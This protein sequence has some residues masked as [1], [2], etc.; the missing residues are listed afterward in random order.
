MSDE[1]LDCLE[2]PPK[3]CLDGPLC[4][5]ATTLT[6]RKPF[7]GKCSEFR[8]SAFELNVDRLKLSDLPNGEVSEGFGIPTVKSL[9]IGA[10]RDD[11]KWNHLNLAMERMSGIR[12]VITPPGQE[13]PDWVIRKWPHVTFRTLDARE[14]SSLG[15]DCKRLLTERWECAPNDADQW[16]R[17]IETH[18]N[19]AKCLLQFL[20]RL[21]E[22]I[23]IVN[24]RRE[25]PP[26]YWTQSRTP[27][28]ESLRTLAGRPELMKEVPKILSEAD[29]KCVD[30]HLDA[31]E[32]LAQFTRCDV[33]TPPEERAIDVLQ[34]ALHAHGEQAIVIKDPHY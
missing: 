4:V 31:L 15:R 32:H 26:L 24:L 8:N 14:G 10:C 19:E 22:L 27:A 1:H 18:P 2:L 16:L 6:M 25:G 34:A 11:I 5:S 33:D 9:R 30:G 29:A 17:S 28:L 13:P 7:Q 23:E 12:E 20:K 21:G 3:R